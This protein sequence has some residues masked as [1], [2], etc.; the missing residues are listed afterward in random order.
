M[1]KENKF[2][3]WPFRK[4][5]KEIL[6]EEDRTP[7]LKFFFKLLFRRAGSLVT[8]NFM[9]LF[10][11]IPIVIGAFLY[12]SAPTTPTTLSPLYAPIYGVSM[13]S[14]SPSVSVWLTTINMQLGLPVLSV[15]RSCALIAVGLFL[16]L[17]WGIQN[18]GAAYVLRGMFRG[19]AV[20]VFSDYFYGIRKNWKQAIGI[21]ILDVGLLALLVIDFVALYQRTGAFFN[22]FMYFMIMAIGIIYFFM[23]FYIYQLMITFDMKWTKILKNSLIFSMLGIKRNLLAGLG[24]AFMVAV[25]ALLIVFLLP[26]MTIPMILPCFYLFSF[27]AFMSVY[28]AYPVIDRYLIQPYMAAQKTSDASDASDTEEDSPD[29]SES[30]PTA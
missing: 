6:E 30:D 9:M 15:G 22:D 19:D 3:W 12:I 18:V 24:I 13:I 28:A 7:T 29:A 11:I 23:R 25:N 20:F 2:Q 8:L 27:S 4:E 17:T 1:E 14:D 16:A 21:G 26:F 10:L 5:P